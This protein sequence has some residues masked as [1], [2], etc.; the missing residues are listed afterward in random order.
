MYEYQASVLKN[1]DGD[2]IH[3]RIDLGVDVRVD[4][5]LRFAGINAPEL[6]T[7]EGV[8]SAQFVAHAIPADASIV[9]RT[10]KDRREKY[11]RYLA[12]IMLSD[13]SCLNQTLIDEGLAVPYGDLPV[14]PPQA[15]AS[16]LTRKQ[17]RQRKRDAANGG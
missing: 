15:A 1:V 11:G 2:T 14:S 12:W 10:A 7:P 8:V 13:G 3:A 17:R 5:T 9:V 16:P 4:V 6:S